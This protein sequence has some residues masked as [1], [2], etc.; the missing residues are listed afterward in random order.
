[1]STDGDGARVYQDG[2][3][4]TLKDLMRVLH[5][6]RSSV[7][8]LIHRGKLPAP[9]HLDRSA[10][11]RWRDVRKALERLKPGLLPPANRGAG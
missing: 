6:G 3:L 5:M 11:W 9:V 10:R 4:L 7:Y 2:D 8:R 1:M